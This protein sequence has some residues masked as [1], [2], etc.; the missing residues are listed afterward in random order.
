MEL[1]SASGRGEA[2]VELGFEDVARIVGA[3]PP[4]AMRFR[5]WWARR[6]YRA[7]LAGRIAAHS[8][9]LAPELSVHPRLAPPPRAAG[10]R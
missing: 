6:A 7:A 8:A 4:S 10:R 2:F 5:Q 9:V 3:L 1:R